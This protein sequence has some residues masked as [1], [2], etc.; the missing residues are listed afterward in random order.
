M[1]L[2]VAKDGFVWLI[3]NMNEAIDF[4]NASNISIYRLYEDGSEGEVLSEEDIMN[5]RGEFGIEAG[6]IKDL[7]PTCA[8]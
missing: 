8:K 2:K 4:Y 1:R 5:H 6:F 7:L 3:L